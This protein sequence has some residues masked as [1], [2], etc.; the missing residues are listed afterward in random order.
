[1][2]VSLKLQDYSFVLII[3]FVRPFDNLIKKDMNILQRLSQFPCI[4]IKVIDLKRARQYLIYS[5]VMIPTYFFYK[6]YNYCFTNRNESN[7]VFPKVKQI[8]YTPI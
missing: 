5:L 7:K 3:P 2:E 6:A 8:E 1:M 4:L